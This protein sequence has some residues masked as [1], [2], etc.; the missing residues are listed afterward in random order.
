MILQ[1]GQKINMAK[2]R[3]SKEFDDNVKEL[4]AIDPDSV[5][6]AKVDTEFN[7]SVSGITFEA[8]YEYSAKI[9]I[10]HDMRGRVTKYSAA[11]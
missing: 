11:K 5:A 9:F 4:I 8:G 7:L 3:S 6:S 10:H 1:K 2:I